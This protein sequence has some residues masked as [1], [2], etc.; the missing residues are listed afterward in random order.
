LDAPLVAVLWQILFARCF[1]V[2]LDFVPVVLL[3]TTVWLIYSADRA[4]DAWRGECAS[5]RHQF[6]RNY[7]TSLAPF[8][9][10]VF[11]VTA[12]IAIKSLSQAVFQR[13]LLVL[14]AVIVYLALVHWGLLRES[15]SMKE[16]TVGL[17]FALGASLMAWSKVRSA[18]DASTILL[19]AGLC[20]LNCVAIHIWEGHARSSILGPVGIGFCLAACPLLFLHRPVL[21]GAE[22]ASAGGLL[23]LNLAR[24][25]L[26]RNALRVL[27][28]VALL[29]P[30]IF[31]PVAGLF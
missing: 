15:F 9:F 31:L 29:S 6:Y 25:H 12:W 24:Q 19:F 23:V 26:S 14:L 11:S 10:A 2:S 27:A 3:A 28:D 8:W 4:L 1:H 13:G 21:G 20:W 17:V 7:G 18:A 22:I 30:V 5:L 16:A